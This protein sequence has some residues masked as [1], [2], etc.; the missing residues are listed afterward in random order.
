MG[1]LLKRI[2]EW[3]IIKAIFRSGRRRGQTDPP[4][5]GA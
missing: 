1:T 2:M 3:K 5:G 4:R